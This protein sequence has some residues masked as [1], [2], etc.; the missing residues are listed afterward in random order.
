L[1]L[2]NQDARRYLIGPTC[3]SPNVGTSM[4]FRPVATMNLKRR[5]PLSRHLFEYATDNGYK[6][7]KRHLL[8]L[9]QLIT[10]SF[11]KL[12]LLQGMASYDNNS[13]R[14][15]E[16]EAESLMVRK[17][18][19]LYGDDAGDDDSSNWPKEEAVE[20]EVSF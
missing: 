7:P 20:K 19:R 15:L 5:A 1:S 13:K 4:N 17:R 9:V 2:Q 10:L 18:L 12:S 3:R 6:M 16:L 8:S 11:S 14:K